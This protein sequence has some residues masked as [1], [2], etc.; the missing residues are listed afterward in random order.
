LVAM[1]IPRTQHLCVAKRISSNIIGG[2]FLTIEARQPSSLSRLTRVIA[3]RA[4]D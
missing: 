2:L 1:V 4:F 3:G